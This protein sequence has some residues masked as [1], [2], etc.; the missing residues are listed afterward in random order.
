MNLVVGATGLVGNHICTLLAD[1]GKPVRALV[2]PTSNTDRIAQLRSIG[3][4]IV[5]G[6][7]KD[8]HSL[9]IACRGAHAV[10]ST[11]SSTL[12][13][14]QGDSIDSVDR[15]GQLNLVEAA[16]AAGVKHFVFISFPDTPIDYPLQTAKRA[17][18]DRL[19][20][21]RMTHTILQPTFFM[22]VWLSPSLGFDAANGTAQIYGAGDKKI[23]WI[24]FQ[25]VARFA[26]AALEAPLA[27]NA[28]VKLGGP[29]ALSPLEVVRTVEAATGKPVTVQ[30]VPE[31]A[32]RGQ[33]NSAT[34]DLQKSFAALMM[35]YA[36]GEVIDA[37][38][39]HRIFPI[40]RLTSVRDYLTPA[41]AAR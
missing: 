26:V 31:E 3:A 35:Y 36:K 1:G 6:D 11:A 33:Y 9:E 37:G 14:Q 10:L 39:A 4:E 29:N 8:A 32:L 27:A 21:S 23:S 15:Q 28:T 41:P 19:R 30:H 34:D 22:E 12:S 17:V 18:E 38:E 16:E 25:D 2:R 40:N 24:S 7:L 20:R 13:R 5:N